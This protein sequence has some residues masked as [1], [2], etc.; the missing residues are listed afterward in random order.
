MKQ[1]FCILAILFVS[2]AVAVRFSPVKT[3][4]GGTVECIVCKTIVDLADR[5]IEENSTESE[6]EE[7][8]DDK[9]CV[10]MKGIGLQGACDSFVNTYGDQMITYFVQDIFNKDEICVTL[11]NVCSN[12]TVYN[13]K[14][15]HKIN[16]I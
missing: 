4:V 14:P 15:F 12:G 5:F 13:N 3:K 10:L 16:Q 11:L 7:F 1:L 2:Y 6:I 9:V 8:V